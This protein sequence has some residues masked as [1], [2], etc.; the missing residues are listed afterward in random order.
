M[1]ILVEPNQVPDRW[2]DHTY[3]FHNPVVFVPRLNDEEF[4]SVAEDIGKRLQSTKGRAVM[5]L[6]TDGT[7]SYAKPGGPLR[8]QGSDAAF[9]SALKGALPDSIEVVESNTH[10]EDP[11]FV[12]ACVDRLI[13][14]IE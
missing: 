14:M 9:F 13:G 10:A 5:M 8:D 1:G 4:V 11:E 3:V 2:K 6:P 12:R 7:G